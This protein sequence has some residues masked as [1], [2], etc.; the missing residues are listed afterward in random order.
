MPTRELPVKSVG[1]APCL[2]PMAATCL[3]ILLCAASAMAQRKSAAPAPPPPPA[4]ASTAAPA[5]LT[6]QDALDRARQYSPGFRAAVVA[7]QIAHQDTVQARAR[8]GP[9]VLFTSGYL[10]T[11]GNGTIASRFIANNGVHEY[12]AQGIAHEDLFNGTL[13]AGYRRAEAL[14]SLQRAQQEIAQRGLAATVTGNYYALVVAQREYATAQR[15]AREARDFLDISRNLEK[16]GE[17]AHSDTIKAELQLRDKQRALE[18]ARLAMNRSRLDLAVLLAP[19]LDQNFTVVDDLAT[20]P[21]L[22]PM[23]DVQN[24]AARN[25]P[26]IRAAVA[27]LHAANDNILDA[28]SGYL[29]TITFDYYYGIDANHFATYTDRVKNL[30]Y[31]AM[32]TFTL[33]VWN[34]GA[35]HS[36]VRQALLARQ[37]ARTQLS[38]TQRSLLANLQGAYDEAGAARNELTS[39]ER[40]TELAAESLRLTTMRYQAGEATVLEVVDAQNTLIAARDAYDA[41]QMR[42]RV[43]IAVLQTLTGPF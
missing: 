41:G 28:R 3:I 40:S 32:A 37:Q 42:Y 25:N 23:A 39:L 22:P 7:A 9:S 6:L 35:T 13:I 8:F 17:V 36:R 18:E 24:M 21:P 26:E 1:I 14:E 43:D 10:Y 33:P 20:L 12:I 29:P 2:Y 31:A 15:G 4:S 34:W 38:F 19:G 30:G 16:G 27:A 11:A 5:V